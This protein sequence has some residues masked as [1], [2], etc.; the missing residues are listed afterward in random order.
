MPRP[1]LS[2]FILFLTLCTSLSFSPS[3]ALS[4]TTPQLEPVNLQL[5]W[6]HQFQFAGYYA[7][8]AKGYYLE[9]GLDVTLLEGGPD[10]N[11]INAVLGGQAQYG[12]TNAEILLHKINGKPLVVLAAIFQHSPLVFVARE[13]KGINHPQDLISK[14]VKM[15]RSSRDIELQTTLM[16]EGISLDQLKILEGGASYHDYFA[17]EIDAVSAYITNQP[18]YYKA[19]NVGFSLIRPSA[20]GV[21]FYGDCLFTSERERKNHPER[22]E[23]FRRASLRGWEYAM[24][25]TEEIIEI[26]LTTYHSKKSRDHLRY[27]AQEMQK[28]ILPELVEIGQM[29]PGRWNHIADTFV[30]NKMA[31]PD[32]SLK[33]FIY[34]PGDD[35]DLTGIM[36]LIGLLAIIITVVTV[37]AVTLFVFNKR[38]QQ[39]IEKHETT[40]AA[41]QES[42]SE[43]ISY[44]NQMEQFSLSAASMLSMKDEQLIFTKISQAIVDYSDFRRVLISLFKDEARIGI[45][46]A[47]AASLKRSSRKCAKLPCRR[48]GMIRSSAKVSTWAGSA[49]T[50][51]TP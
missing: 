24:S 2:P 38:L 17:P 7:A 21:D 30:R 18:Y 51:R 15:S 4:E 14:R 12:V 5:R 8:L 42:E 44:S 41:L 6:L 16:N 9:A 32:Y 35:L 48:A 34:T 40:E 31:R 19:N 50:S 22:V 20:Y 49:T 11:T 23:A 43:L 28:L 10:K 36:Q 29:N 1:N 47:M 46:S 13:E 26:I 37:V 45:S 25:H 27:E 39:E 33:G 3:R